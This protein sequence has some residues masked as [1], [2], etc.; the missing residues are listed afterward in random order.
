M[1]MFITLYS[2]FLT[3]VVYFFSLKAAKK[4]P[5][6]LMSPLFIATVMIILILLISG[7]SYEQYQPANEIITYL[8]G[9]ATVSL[10]VPLYKNKAALAKYLLPACSGMFLG[11]LSTIAVALLLGVFFAFSTNILQALTVKSVTVPIAVEIA[12]LYDGDP[13]LAAAFVI[14]TGL[15]GAML[16]PWLMDRFHITMPFARGIA[17][18]TIAHGIGTAQATKESELTGAVSGAAMGIAAMITPLFFPVISALFL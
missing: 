12:A 1:S 9:P 18:G 17:F 3:I 11:L 7:V 16:G 6:S 10:A 13:E 14:I 2:L 15:L 4:Y 5:S 8:L